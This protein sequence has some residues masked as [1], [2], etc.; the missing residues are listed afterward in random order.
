[1]HD[2]ATPLYRTTRLDLAAATI[3]TAT[4]LVAFLLAPRGSQ[5]EMLLLAAAPIAALVRV[6]DFAGALART[7]LLAACVAFGAYITINA[8]WSIDP[9]EAYGKVLFYWVLLVTAHLAITGLSTVSDE[10]LDR[11]QKA[12]VIA[13]MAG[14]VFLLIEVLTDQAIKRFIFSLLPFARPPPKHTK[15]V[16]GEVVEIGAYILNRNMAALCL[17]LGPV[18]LMLRTLLDARRTLIAGLALVA[19][20]FVAVL[21]SEHE[22]SMIAMVLACAAF[23]GMVV[24]APVMR[25]A[26]AAGW[27]IATLL[28]VPMVTLAYKQQLHFSEW[29]PL[30]ARNRVILWGYT[31]GEVAK[32]PI[33]GIGVAS[34]K[35]LDKA[36]AE[37]AIQPPGYTYPLRTAQ[38][39]HNIFL[40]TWYELGAI[41]AA[42]LLAMGLCALDVLSR[43]PKRDQALAFA[44]FVAAV[45]IGSFTWGIW[46]TWFM[47]AYGIWALLLALAFEGSRRQ[48]ARG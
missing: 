29:L 15:V 43:L 13:V 47:A 39:A 18:L 34:T 6:G 38:H 28:V 26:I 32:T 3:L 14:A 45:L 40:Q 2:A 44:S 42:L 19:V 33:L 11:L 12:A 37:K 16:D 4:A 31:A 23:A 41:G 5:F 46:Q 21:R 7:P 25:K 35:E 9:A 1:M 8:A 30:T 36:N 24:A 22:T 20:S 17:V 27:V 10:V 48:E